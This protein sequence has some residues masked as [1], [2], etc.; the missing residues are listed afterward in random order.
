MIGANKNAYSDDN[1]AT[2][3]AGGALS[4]D[5]FCVVRDNVH[6]KFII[7]SDSFSNVVNYSADATSWSNVAVSLISPLGGIAM[8]SNGHAILCG[9]SS[10]TQPAFEVSTD[11]GATWATTGGTVPSAASYSDAGWVVGN[12][13]ATIWHVGTLSNQTVVCS[14][15]DGVTWTRVLAQT[16]VSN[17]VVNPV[18][19]CDQ[20]TGMLVVASRLSNAATGFVA[21]LDGGVTWFGPRT[22]LGATVFA[23]SYAVAGGRLFSCDGAG[24]F[25]AS[26]GIGL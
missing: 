14:S 24:I 2:W 22:L 15:A 7:S 23:H 11:G 20:D 18:I 9:A 1:G 17:P 8:L 25:R 4:G 21:S 26:D 10:G 6:S 16:W 3:A 12:G 5:P 13:G 19:Y